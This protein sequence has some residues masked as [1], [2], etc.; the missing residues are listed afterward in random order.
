MTSKDDFVSFVKKHY[1]VGPLYLIIFS[2]LT[3]IAVGVALQQFYIINLNTQTRYNLLWHIPFNLF[4]FWYW[5]LLLP[6][7][8][9]VTRSFRIESSKALYW[10]SIYFFFPVIAV[11]VHQ[12]LASL[13]INLALGYLDIPT[14]I[15][16]RMLRNPW[17]GL[18]V[19]IYFV[20]M[21][22]INVFDYQQKNRDD[23]LKL[24]Q[25]QGQLVQS[26]LR[27]LESQLHPHFLFNTL[28]AVSTLILKKENAEAERM[29]SLLHDFLETTIHGSER[30]MILLEEELRFINH[31]LEIEKVR[32]AGRLDV[33]EDISPETLAA[34][35]PNL[36]LQ[37][38]VENA[39]RYAI[40]PQKSGG[41][42]VI[43]ARK[44]GR[45]LS[46][47]VEDNGPGISRATVRRGHQ[48]VGHRITGQRLF[49]L[50]GDDHVFEFESKEAG[51]LRV[52][53]EI[54]FL[55]G[56]FAGVGA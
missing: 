17:L 7:M 53:I 45:H 38:I 33:S 47:I 23:E 25:I 54:P 11:F 1:F 6:L 34:G 36:I 44:I 49:H 22:A 12:I 51:G 55:V 16:K 5:F 21:M 13:A 27:A 26:Q 20:I 32:F 41:K 37:P 39:V 28:N 30:H 10:V 29:L 15:Y 9:W 43:T 46:V 40:A 14:L 2:A 8:D 48:G 18:D 42:I 3:L 52:R 24:A 56:D 35:V 31:Y 4:Y 50:F 19:V